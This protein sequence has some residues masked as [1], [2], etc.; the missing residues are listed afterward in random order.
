MTSMN[1]KHMLNNYF[2]DVLQQLNIVYIFDWKSKAKIDLRSDVAKEDVRNL[3]EL[4]DRYY[5]G[6][7]FEKDLCMITTFVSEVVQPHTLKGVEVEM[8]I[9]EYISKLG[10]CHVGSIF[11]E[12]IVLSG[13]DSLVF[14]KEDEWL[15]AMKNVEVKYFTEEKKEKLRNIQEKINLHERIINEIESTDIYPFL[16]DVI[17]GPWV[18]NFM[19]FCIAFVI[20]GISTTQSMP[21][22]YLYLAV[23]IIVGMVLV[24]TIYI[25]SKRKMVSNV[26][27]FRQL[28]KDYI[29]EVKYYYIFKNFHR[30]MYN[31]YY[32]KSL[33]NHYYY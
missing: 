17:I 23:T 21:N 5:A 26:D 9:D 14:I 7:Q 11:Q 30:E 20:L 2:M 12:D 15:K 29:N 28:Q 25:V 16:R 13:F 4:I 32:L 24:D 1:K 8:F 19:V 22:V 27:K 3:L 18:V 10:G 6:E 31:K 33:D